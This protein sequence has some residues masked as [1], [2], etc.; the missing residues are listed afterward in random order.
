MQVTEMRDR[1]SI[2]PQC[3][4]TFSLRTG[5]E[6]IDDQR[7]LFLTVDVE[8]RTVATHL[9]LDPGP[10]SRQEVDVRFILGWALLAK[11]EPRPVGMRDVL[12][13]MIPPLLILGAAVGG[14]QVKPVVGLH[15][16][17]QPEGDAHKAPRALGGAWRRRAGQF[18][19]DAAVG[20]LEALDGGELFEIWFV[21][22]HALGPAHGLIGHRDPQPLLA[23]Q[24]GWLSGHVVQAQTG[25]GLERIVL[26]LTRGRLRHENRGNDRDA[27]QCRLV[28][29]KEPHAAFL[30]RKR[31]LM[32]KDG[33][34]CVRWR[35]EVFGNGSPPAA[36]RVGSV[37]RAHL[38]AHIRL[39][40]MTTRHSAFLV[41][42]S[43][44]LLMAGVP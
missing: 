43:S 7:R 27:Q 26:G 34:R 21:R 11:P 1:A 5:L 24:R 33:F 44:T 38:A 22:P 31:R 15:I 30:L 28:K 36:S 37:S 3:D 29:M 39:A 18:Y 14:T 2:E 10:D 40:A 32:G 8:T 35:D 41:L 17:L 42:V 19:L 6:V 23:L 20:E 25:R 12:S 13:G 9:D 16:V 4:R